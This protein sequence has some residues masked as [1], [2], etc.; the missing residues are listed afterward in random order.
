MFAAK[1]ELAAILGLFNA[2]IRLAKAKIR[3]LIA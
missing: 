3:P 2:G 1:P